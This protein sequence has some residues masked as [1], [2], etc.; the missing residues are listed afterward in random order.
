MWIHGFTGND[1]ANFQVSTDHI[2]YLK[3]EDNGTAKLSLSNGKEIVIT[4]DS[5]DEFMT[6]V[7]ARS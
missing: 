3:R 6:E 4:M 2:V 5:Y 7:D 1:G